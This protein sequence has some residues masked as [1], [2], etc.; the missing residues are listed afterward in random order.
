MLVL[1]R[2]FFFINIP[3]TEKI[4]LWKFINRNCSEVCSFKVGAWGFRYLKIMIF[5]CLL[6]ESY[7]SLSEVA[8]D[9]F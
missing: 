7:P 5:L 6:K 3:Y 2:I 1:E 8:V 9:E 4:L